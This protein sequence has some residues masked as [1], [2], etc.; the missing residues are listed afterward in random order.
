MINPNYKL[1]KSARELLKHPFFD[2]VSLLCGH[3]SSAG[4]LRSYDGKYTG[5]ANNV[6][7]NTKT[8]PDIKIKES[9]IDTHTNDIHLIGFISSILKLQHRTLFLAVDLYYRCV[10]SILNVDG[11]NFVIICILI[12]SKLFRNYSSLSSLMSTL[13][14]RLTTGYNIKHVNP[15]I[16]M[17]YE[18]QIVKHLNGVIWRR[19]IF[20]SLTNYS[21]LSKSYSILLNPKKYFGEHV[22]V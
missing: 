22:V 19:Y 6:A 2:D 18:L 15:D 14:S 20:D 17:K 12:A 8:S 3:T 1:R 9:N 13:I 4:I 21:E 7:Q 11:E 5:S 10:G 16:I